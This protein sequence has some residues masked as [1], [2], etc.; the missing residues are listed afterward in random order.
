MEKGLVL[1]MRC[2]PPICALGPTIPWAVGRCLD[3]D[4]LCSTACLVSSACPTTALACPSTITTTTIT[5]TNTT[6]TSLA[7]P[8]RTTALVHTN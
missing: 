1:P 8:H 5:T 4:T 2:K 6:T 3:P 7:S